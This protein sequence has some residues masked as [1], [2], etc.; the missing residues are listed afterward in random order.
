VIKDAAATLSVLSEDWKRSTWAVKEY[1]FSDEVGTPVF[2]LKAKAI[3][4]TLAITGIPYID[5]TQSIKAGFEKLDLEL[6]KKGL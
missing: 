3:G 1:F 4:P 2:L 6:N 5:F